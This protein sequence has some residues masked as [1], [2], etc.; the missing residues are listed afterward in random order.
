MTE[1]RTVS[2]SSGAFAFCRWSM[3][4]ILWA[5]FIL[6][7]KVLVVAALVILILSAILTVKWAPLVVL[8]TYTIDRL[9]PSR[10]TD[11]GVA[12][13]R[14]AHGMGSLLGFAAVA[15]L[16][17]NEPVGW[18]IVLAFCLLKTVSAA[19]FCP[20]SRLYECMTSGTCCAF[21]RKNT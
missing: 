21:L 1:Q 12:G 13:M 19:G 11:L 20:A 4:I 16:Y 18:G 7:I 2:V 10:Q 9:L 6:K 3:A 14:F 15:F 8:Y 17:L 5:A